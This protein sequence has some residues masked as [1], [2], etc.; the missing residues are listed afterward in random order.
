MRET[1][2]DLGDAARVRVFSVIIV[3][4]APL[5]PFF[6]LLPKLG[7]RERGVLWR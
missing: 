7:G 1:E 3:G 5:D 6:E 4:L 2:R